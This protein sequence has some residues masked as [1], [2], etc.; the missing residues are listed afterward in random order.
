MSNYYVL[1]RQAYVSYI[2]ASGILFNASIALVPFAVF[3]VSFWSDVSFRSAASNFLM[4]KMQASVS[5]RIGITLLE[6]N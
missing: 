1:R 4:Q 5:I 3:N 6:E 2:D